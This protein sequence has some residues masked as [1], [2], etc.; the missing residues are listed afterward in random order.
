M[1][2]R[3]LVTPVR[4]ELHI[5]V[6]DFP[7]LYAALCYVK[8]QYAKDP[9]RLMKIV[10]HTIDP[11][12]IGKRRNTYYTVFNPVTD[13]HLSGVPGDDLTPPCA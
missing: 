11:S 12:V 13:E 10:K 8:R 7:R 4:T 5:D 1:N 6:R 3:Y 9:E 2:S